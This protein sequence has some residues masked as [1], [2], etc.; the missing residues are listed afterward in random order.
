MPGV[1]MEQDDAARQLGMEEK[2]DFVV[3]ARY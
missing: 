2:E 1:S 3:L